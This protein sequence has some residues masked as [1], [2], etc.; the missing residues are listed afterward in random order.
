M[1]AS[2]MAVDVSVLS[3]PKTPAIDLYR[4]NDA[5]PETFEEFRFW[6]TNELNRIQ[7][8]GISSDEAVLIL[9]QA[10]EAIEST[11]CECT[12]GE[13]GPAGPAGPAGRDG[14]DGQDGQDGNAGDL[15]D[16]NKIRYTLT[17]SSEKINLE[18]SKRA[19]QSALTAHIN[20]D[21]MHNP[22]Q[23]VDGGA[24]DSVYFWGI[25]GGA[26]DSLA[27]YFKRLDGGASV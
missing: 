1:Q 25:D 17:W 26:A 5:T 19:L 13:Q 3:D 22:G 27:S 16:D 9:A 12:G 21:T 6:I 4:A 20:D 10:I 23:L 7:A 2:L 24:S 15:I 11:D 14:V 18:L 8:M